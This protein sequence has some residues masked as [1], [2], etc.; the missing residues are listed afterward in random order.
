MKY[1]IQ[2]Y[3]REKCIQNNAGNHISM[4]GGVPKKLNLLRTG[5]LSRAPFGV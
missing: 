2:N 4:K 3:K 5:F 1:A